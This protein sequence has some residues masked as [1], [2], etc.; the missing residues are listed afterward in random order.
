MKLLIPSRILCNGMNREALQPHMQSTTFVT[1]PRL[2][3]SCIMER[4][5]YRMSQIS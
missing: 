3:A 5:L 1:F 2:D 4:T